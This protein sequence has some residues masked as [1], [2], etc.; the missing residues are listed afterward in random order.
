MQRRYSCSGEAPQTRCRSESRSPDC[1]PEHDSTVEYLS[2]MPST[3]SVSF[4]SSNEEVVYRLHS[5]TWQRPASHR[6]PS[7][8]I[9]AILLLPYFNCPAQ[10]QDVA[11]SAS[12]EVSSAVVSG[13]R[14]LLGYLLHLDVHLGELVAIHGRASYTILFAIVFAE[15]GLVIAP[16]LPGDSL[17]F[18]TGALAASDKLNIYLLLLTYMA[19]AVLGDLVNYTAGKYLG[20]HVQQS[21]LVKKEHLVKTQHFFAKHGGRAVVLGRFLPIVRTFAPFVA[22]MSAMPGSAFAY[23]NVLGAALWTCLCCGGGYV[24]GNVP[25]VRNNFSLVMLAIVVLSILPAAYEV[26]TTRGVRQRKLR[27]AGPGTLTGQ[28]GGLVVS[29]HPSQTGGTSIA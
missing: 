13:L 15:T 23:F 2:D 20:A 19:A 28:F 21:R 29:R 25:L 14:G 6:L 1:S 9:S 5:S 16:F 22:G 26:L 27:L 24:F 11:N 18:A 8:L 17:L 7:L 3:N 10:A 12:P 4:A